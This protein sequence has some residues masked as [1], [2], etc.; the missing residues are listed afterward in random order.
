VDSD[1]LAF[2]PGRLQRRGAGEAFD[3]RSDRG[4]AEPVEVGFAPS[5]AFQ[6]LKL[7][8][9]DVAD[10]LEPVIYETETLPAYGG[11]PPQP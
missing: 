8:V 11:T 7:V 1:I 6:A 3:L 5:T 4:F 2:A 10:R 9:S